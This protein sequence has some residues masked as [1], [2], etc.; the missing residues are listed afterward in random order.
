MKG[1]G[2]QEQGGSAATWEGPGWANTVWQKPEGCLLS[3]WP[4][5]EVP[6]PWLRVNVKST[7]Q[8]GWSLP[9]VSQ[10]LSDPNW[11]VRL[12]AETLCFRRRWSKFGEKVMGFSEHT[13]PVCNLRDCIQLFLAICV[14][15]NLIF[16]LLRATKFRNK[17]VLVYSLIFE[18]A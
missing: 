2:T 13:F 11:F 7:A 10:F 14:A 16:F 5:L 9:R 6:S 3:P 12:L 18:L 17:C 8:G 15:I 4:H 1:E